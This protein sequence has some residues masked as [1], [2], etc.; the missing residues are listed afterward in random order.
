MTRISQELQ[1][2]NRHHINISL[3]TNHASSATTISLIHPT[4]N[5]NNKHTQ[6]QYTLPDY[7][8]S[9]YTYKPHNFH[10]QW[11]ADTGSGNNLVGDNVLN[12]FGYKRD[13]CLEKGDYTDSQSDPYNFLSQTAPPEAPPPAKGLLL[14][15]SIPM[16]KYVEMRIEAYYAPGLPFNPWTAKQAKFDYLTP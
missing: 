2:S 3:P 5:D 12:D 8:T 7:Y 9:A 15:I 13:N 4:G 16:E 1:L 6:E 14:Y 11:I 10:G